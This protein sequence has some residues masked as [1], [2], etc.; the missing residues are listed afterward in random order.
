M[1]NF[2][3]RLQKD[4]RVASGSYPRKWFNP[5]ARH[6]QLMFRYPLSLSLP[7]LRLPWHWQP[8]TFLLQILR[9]GPPPMNKAM[10]AHLNDLGYTAQ[11]Q[12]QFWARHEDSFPFP[13]WLIN[14]Q[15]E[16]ALINLA[17]LHFMGNWLADIL[18]ISWRDLYW[19]FSA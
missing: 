17:L 16:Y 18:H 14:L 19:S 4:G 9:C 8:I 11:M 6:L 10:A 15:E 5:T 7:A 12:F 13:V 1:S 2:T 3:F